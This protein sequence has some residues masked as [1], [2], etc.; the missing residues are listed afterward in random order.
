LN[1][2]EGYEKRVNELQTLYEKEKLYMEKVI[3]IEEV[4]KEDKK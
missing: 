3:G 1:K 4:K 2:K